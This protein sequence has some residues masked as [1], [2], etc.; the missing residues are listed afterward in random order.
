[1]NG[2]RR[3]VITAYG[4]AAAFSVYF[5]MFGFRKPF[6]ALTFDGLPFLESRIELKTACVIAQSIGYL[7]SKYLGT[8]ICA[9]VPGE[10]R[11]W[12]L[13]RLMLLAEFG[14]LLF[15][16]LPDNLKPLAMLIN[17]L[18]LGMVWG[19]VVR[20]LEGRRTSEA[21]I[22]GLS[23]SY[24]IAGAITRDIGRD[25]VIGAWHV[26]AIWMPAATG[27]LFLIPFGVALWFLDRLPPPSP[28]DVV[29][30]SP[31][32][33]MP[34][35]ERRAF[36]LHFRGAM[37]LILMS[38]FLLTAFREFRDQY[39]IELIQAL[40]LSDHRAIFFKTE[41]WAVF[42]A[43]ASMTGLSLISSHRVALVA[44]HAVIVAGFA[45]IGLATAGY[46]IGTISGFAWM[47]WC[48]V[49]M[50]LA[51]VPFGVALFERMMAGSRLAGTSVFAIQLADGIGYTGGV[52]V[53]LV[54]DLAFGQFDRLDFI[55]PFAAVVS[56]AGV[57]LMT[58]S[59]FLTIG[60]VSDASVPR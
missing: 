22:A 6:T 11:A 4:M 16:V 47:A 18:P 56:V 41:Q 20:Y 44:T 59:G 8:K 19:L 45:I 27:A 51:Y 2:T 23:C 25:V 30:R 46:Q 60:R 38:Y 53:Q 28:E 10:R 9:E 34:A 57:L 15:A 50:Y 55:L 39:A 52:L 17:G 48:S 21:L 24:I 12:L 7:L 3:L 36:F 43:I 26:P 33:L 31:R 1:M 42:G 49:G 40:G 54:R 35:A 58:I 37:I 14:L 29:E 32:S 13:F 5:C